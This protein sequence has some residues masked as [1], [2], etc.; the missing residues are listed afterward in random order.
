MADSRISL[1]QLFV[2]RLIPDVQVNRLVTGA[3]NAHTEELTLFQ[4]PHRSL[5]LHVEKPG[6]LDSLI[7]VDNESM[8]KEIGDDELEMEAKAFGLNF[9]DVFI[10]LG[11]M[12]GSTPMGG[13]CAGIVTAVGSRTQSRFRVGD[14]ICAWYATPYANRARVK[15]SFACQIPYSM[16]FVSAASIPVVFLTAYYGLVEIAR[17]GP[18]QTVLI[19]SAAGGVGQAAIMIAKNIGATILAT[20]G[21]SAKRQMLKEKFGI[22]EHHVFSSRT[23]G[24]QRKVL[25]CTGRKGADVVLNSLAGEA[26]LESWDCI[27]RFGTFIEIGKSDIHRNSKLSMKPFERNACFASLDLVGL[28]DHRPEVLSGLLEKLLAMFGDG[29]LEVVLPLTT[30]PIS[31]IESAFRLIQSSK[32]MGKVVLEAEEQSMVRA[33]LP[34]TKALHLDSNH[35]YAV[36]GGLGSL[37]RRV[38]NFLAEHGAKHLLVL[39]RRTLDDDDRQQLEGDLAVLG[40]KVYLERCDISNPEEMRDVAAR[41]RDRLPSVKGV[42]QA[43]MVLQVGLQIY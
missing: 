33:V 30:R 31:Q 13:E 37:G 22:P 11:Q 19:H 38:L 32:H 4:D 27:A 14:R 8:H 42:I 24:F 3:A 18:H 39:S 25:Q 21:N 17:L 40:T 1:G 2:P 16:S 7:F 15:Q 28:A 12:K 20:V 43:A 29:Q 36:A 35:T 6:L 10:A 5:R 26:L 34:Q 9:K 41:C 23:K